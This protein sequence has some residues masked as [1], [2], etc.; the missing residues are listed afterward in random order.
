MSR[1]AVTAALDRIDPDLGAFIELVDRDK[2][3]ALSDAPRSGR[4]SGVLVA[5]K[6]L[7]DTAGLRNTFGTEFFAGHIPEKN[8]PGE[9]GRANR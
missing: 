8:A 1:E 3:L 7:I 4:L 9:I 5:M 6:D 2:V